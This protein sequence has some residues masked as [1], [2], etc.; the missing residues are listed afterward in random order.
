MKYKILS[1]IAVLFFLIL[2]SSVS[3]GLTDYLFVH[4][5]N[6]IHLNETGKWF[7]VSFDSHSAICSG[8]KHSHT[9]LANDTFIIASSGTGIYELHAH[10]SIQDNSTSPDADVVFRFIQN[11]AEILGSLREKDLDKKDDDALASSMVVASLTGNDT[12]KLQIISNRDT[13][14]IQSDFTYGDHKDSAVIKIIKLKSPVVTPTNTT[15]TRFECDVS[16]TPAAIGLIG[17][18]LLIIF[19]WI[20]CLLSKIP[21]LNLL[22]GFIICFFAWFVAACFE[23]AVILFVMIGVS[24]MLYGGFGL[25]GNKKR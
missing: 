19:I 7:N 22:V 17:F 21:V 16:S 1:C 18:M 8:I 4:T 23:F 12:I 13:V 15:L 5:N 14:Y 6:T 2:C 10:L 25:I 20:I 9:S 3:A 24:S 11:G